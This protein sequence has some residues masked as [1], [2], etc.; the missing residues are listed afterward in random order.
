MAY[1]KL[2]LVIVFIWFIVGG[3]GHFAAT[4]LFLRSIPPDWPLRV[5]AVYMSGFFEV[6]GALGLLHLKSRRVAGI[7]L[8]L[9][10]IAVTPANI[11]MW[12]NPQLFPT[13]PEI[14]LTIRLVVQ[15]ILL[16]CIW[17]ATLRAPDE[18]PHLYTRDG[19]TLGCEF[20]RSCKQSAMRSASLRRCM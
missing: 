16:G 18:R 4:D 9:L 8:F 20:M 14:L 5:Q 11:Y 1:K 17:W 2:A 10:T 19:D 7:G 6:L 15:V 13:V 12:L 3:V